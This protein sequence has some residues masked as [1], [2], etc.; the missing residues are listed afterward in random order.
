MLSG[1]MSC[2]LLLPIFSTRVELEYLHGRKWQVNLVSPG[3][4]C[5]EPRKRHWRPVVDLDIRPLTRP[6]RESQSRRLTGWLTGGYK[7][8]TNLVGI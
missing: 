1:L 3:I 2:V 7:Q 4:D 8:M 5:V 6:L